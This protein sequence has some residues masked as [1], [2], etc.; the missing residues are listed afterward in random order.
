MMSTTNQPFRKLLY[1]YHFDIMDVF[2]RNQKSAASRMFQLLLPLEKIYDEN[3]NSFMIRIF[4]DA[5]A[6]EI[7]NIFKDNSSVDTS[8]LVSVLKRV[9]S[10]NSKKWKQID[11]L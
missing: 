6:D 8:Q 4:M 2:E 10:V 3:P 11:S 1:Q 5:K 7:V 9:S